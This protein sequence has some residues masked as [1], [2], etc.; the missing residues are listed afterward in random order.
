M[1]EFLNLPDYDQARTAFSLPVPEVYNFG[2]DLIDKRA[3]ERDKTA[4]IYDD[5]NTGELREI[6]FSDL[7]EASA[8]FANVLTEMGVERD[9]FAFMMIPRIPAW[10]E[11]T[12]GCIKAGVVAMPGTNLL[13]PKDIEYRINK[14]R[15]R[16]ILS[17]FFCARLLP[18]F[19]S[20]ASVTAP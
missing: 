9:A 5:A 19:T 18:T 14:S 7:A 17:I 3:A 1:S 11:A 10:Y 2:F 8:R 16:K 4:L 15:A 6:R 12:I 13:M 20:G